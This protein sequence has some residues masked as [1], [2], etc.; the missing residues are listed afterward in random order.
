MKE[1]HSRHNKD[2][3]NKD[4]EIGFAVTCPSTCREF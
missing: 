1:L 2:K 4:L 3:E